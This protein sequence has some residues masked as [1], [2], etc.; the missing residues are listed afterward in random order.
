MIHKQCDGKIVT[1]YSFKGGVGRTMAMAHVAFMVATSGKRV[2]V[3]DW[4]LEAPGLAYYFRGLL[5]PAVVRKIRTSPGVLDILWKWSGAIKSAKRVT[6]IDTVHAE[7]KSG[8]PFANCVQSLVECGVADGYLSETNKKITLDYLGAGAPVISTPRE[9]PYE[10][11]LAAFS[12]MSFY[13]EHAGGFVLERLREWAKENYDFVFIDSRTGL[14]DVAGVCTMQLPDTVALCFV[15]N[16]QNIEGVSKVAGAIKNKRANDIEIRAVPMR[17]RPREAQ[18]ESDGRARAIYDLYK[19]GKLDQSRVQ[20]DVK[21]LAI[22]TSDSVPFYETLSLFDSTN[23]KYDSLTLQYAKL[24]S[25]LT[26]LDVEVPLFSPDFVEQVNRR[27]QPRNSTVDYLNKLKT[28][29]P[30]RIASELQRLLDSAFDAEVDGTLNDDYIVSLVNTVFEASGSYDE[31]EEA[32]A[33][34]LRCVELLRTLAKSQPAVWTQFLID[35]IERVRESAFVSPDV[36]QNL[37][38][39]LDA[40]LA[41]NPTF[42]NSMHRIRMHQFSARRSLA[43]LNPNDAELHLNIARNV[44]DRLENSIELSKDQKDQV[45]LRLI[46]GK[47]TRGDISHRAQEFQ[48]ALIEY[49]EGLRIFESAGFDKNVQRESEHLHGLLNYRIACFTGDLLP[50][51]IAASYVIP[52]V[53][54]VLYEL[55]GID[56]ALA[57]T[58]V[59]RA[60]KEDPNLLSAFVEH[61]LSKS[62]AR[63]IISAQVRTPKSGIRFAQILRELA[64]LVAN[65][66]KI[67]VKEPLMRIAEV[68]N[69]YIDNIFRRS[70]SSRKIVLRP[71][72]S[73]MAELV[74]VVGDAGVDLSPYSA[75]STILRSAQFTINDDENSDGKGKG[76]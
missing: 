44:I 1:F 21:N 23:P 5:D 30:A 32:T 69:F 43:I 34:Q 72:L 8:L 39:E 68:A 13:E 53:K 71:A 35:T 59:L 75:L 66:S 18:E 20:E 37:F 49:S 11:A 46:D 2:L 38:E 42:D 57:A 48:S 19:V 54:S 3:M 16:R 10:D 70:D 27:M 45:K 62:R 63:R 41:D 58:V 64:V 33:Q 73:E 55:G 4:D 60:S 65:N 67:D 51:V 74:S 24:A 36:E 56:F 50:P 76:L 29:E 9:V 22:A 14:A 26:G 40:L 28:A 7:F 12:W 47:I 17:I 25:E 52:A 31:F 6:D 61:S 15:L